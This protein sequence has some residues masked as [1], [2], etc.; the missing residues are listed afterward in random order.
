MIRKMPNASPLPLMRKGQSL[1]YIKRWYICLNRLTKQNILVIQ[2]F[3]LESS[4][5]DFCDVSGTDVVVSIFIKRRVECLRTYI[6]SYL[7]IIRRTPF[8]ASILCGMTCKYRLF[9]HRNSSSFNHLGVDRY[10]DDQ[11]SIHAEEIVLQLSHKMS[12]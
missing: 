7:T 9:V 1:T 8:Y 12:I 2:E 10:T 11:N 4:L 3:I 6:C 5:E